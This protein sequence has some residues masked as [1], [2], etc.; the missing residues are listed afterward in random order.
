MIY[1]DGRNGDNKC[2]T[3][4]SEGATGSDCQGSVEVS[5]QPETSA[6]LIGGDEN[7]DSSEPSLSLALKD[8][9]SVDQI[10]LTAPTSKGGL[11]PTVTDEPSEETANNNKTN[12]ATEKP[13]QPKD[14]TETDLLDIHR[15]G[16]GEWRFL[17]KG[18][19][20]ISGLVILGLS[21]TAFVTILSLAFPELVKQIYSHFFGDKPSG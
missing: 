4:S 20:G 1:D 18:R 9:S 21:L 19:W 8:A 2:G 15:K 6:T 3:T 13:L 5:G 17:G 14:N 11:V 10:E 7:D 12:D 16:K